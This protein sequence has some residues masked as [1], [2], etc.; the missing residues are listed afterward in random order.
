MLRDEVEFRVIGGVAT[1]DG[2]A[3]WTVIPSQPS[4]SD[5]AR[6]WAQSGMS[7]TWYDRVVEP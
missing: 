6:L 5:L 2:A 7:E 4:T 1:K 3:R